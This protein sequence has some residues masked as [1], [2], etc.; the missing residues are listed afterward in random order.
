MIVVSEST[1]TDDAG[2]RDSDVPEPECSS[3][4]VE[5]EDVAS[6]IDF[7]VSSS[8]TRKSGVTIHLIPI[9]PL[10][11]ANYDL[12]YPHGIQGLAIAFEGSP[13]DELEFLLPVIDQATYAS[14]L[15]DTRVVPQRVLLHRK[16]KPWKPGIVFMWPWQDEAPVLMPTN[17][18]YITMELWLRQLYE[19]GI[20]APDT[21]LSLTVLLKKADTWTDILPFPY[22]Q[23]VFEL[24]AL[25]PHHNN[26]MENLL[27]GSKNNLYSIW[28]PGSIPLEIINQFK[29]GQKRF[30][31]PD[32]Y[33]KV[34]IDTESDIIMD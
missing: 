10:V 6:S 28:S 19:C 34:G 9:R 7:H 24:S 17:T 12:L 25:S 22:F 11:K 14:A 31:A 2:S 13:Q 8:L 27:K 23:Q 3:T 15:V 5:D 20:Y 21:Q 30:L 32:D 26:S 29:L 1:D 16:G 33:T 4:N 18:S